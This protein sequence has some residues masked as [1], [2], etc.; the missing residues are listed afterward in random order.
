MQQAISEWRSS[1]ANEF[2]VLTLLSKAGHAG[3]VGPDAGATRARSQ[4]LATIQ[5]L[6]SCQD[7]LGLQNLCLSIVELG[8]TADWTILAGL[9]NLQWLNLNETQVAD[10]TPLYEIENLDL[11]WEKPERARMRARSGSK[12][13]AKPVGGSS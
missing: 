1:W 8:L 13:R 5:C 12:S 9:K 10:V 7:V 11:S 6:K 2:P 4:R 3:I